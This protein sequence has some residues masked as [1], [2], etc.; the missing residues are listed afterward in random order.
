[1][2]PLGFFPSSCI[3]S[4][5]LSERFMANPSSPSLAWRSYGF[6]RADFSKLP[7]LKSLL[8]RFLPVASASTSSAVAPPFAAMSLSLMAL[9]L[10]LAAMI[11]LFL[12]F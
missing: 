6:D 9:S 8:S 10:A 12:S 1:V 5:G 7:L 2:K 3:D 11:S 4:L